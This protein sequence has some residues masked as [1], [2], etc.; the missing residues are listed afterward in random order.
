MKPSVG[1]EMVIIGI[2]SYMEKHCD[3]PCVQGIFQKNMENLYYDSTIYEFQ[4]VFPLTKLC[5]WFGF[6]QTLRNLHRVGKI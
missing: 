6:S 5:F 4:N 2:Y 3:N 1:E